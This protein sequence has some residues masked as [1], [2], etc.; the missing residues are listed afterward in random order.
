[1][2]EPKKEHRQ[3]GKDRKG[4]KRDLPLTAAEGTMES[5]PSLDSEVVTSLEHRLEAAKKT[6]KADAKKKRVEQ[7]LGTDAGEAKKPKGKGRGKGKKSKKQASD[8]SENPL[9]SEEDL[10]SFEL[11]EPSSGSDTLEFGAERKRKPALKTKDDKKRPASASRVKF[12]DDKELGDEKSKKRKQ[13]SREQELCTVKDAKDTKKTKE[14]EKTD[15]KPKINKDEIEQSERDCEPKKKPTKIQNDNKK[16]EV[17]KSD[18]SKPKTKK[19]KEIDLIESDCEPKPKKNKTTNEVEKKARKPKHEKD[20]IEKRTKTHKDTKNME[21]AKSDDSNPNEEIEQS[22][23]D[24]E[25]KPETTKDIKKTKEVEKNVRKQKIK[26]D[27]IEQSETDCEPKPKKNKTTK[28]VE[29]KAHKP[30]HN[31]DD[32]EKRTKTQKDTKSTEVAKSDDSKPNEEIEQSENDCEPK[33]ET[34]KEKKVRKPK[35]DKDEIERSENAGATRQRKPKKNAKSETLQDQEVDE[36]PGLKERLA[37]RSAQRRLK[38]KEAGKL[39]ETQQ[40]AVW[41]SYHT[42]LQSISMSRCRVDGIKFKFCKKNLC[43]MNGVLDSKTFNLA[44]PCRLMVMTT[45]WLLRFKLMLMLFK[46]AST[47]TWIIFQSWQLLNLNHLELW[48]WNLF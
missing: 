40:T 3:D 32:I 47:L 11:P 8:E 42:L 17:A 31:K 22:E 6:Q 29:K 44:R 23:N 25:P 10:S 38:D 43:S 5:N 24:C 20:E 2:S 9:D 30:K 7:F 1:M 39:M 13:N 16:K 48:R 36:K 46:I 19:D 41:Q 26:K 34:T 15:R 21:V 35:I 4:T 37:A 33:P 12:E 27:E 28:E 18:E 45:A 14:V